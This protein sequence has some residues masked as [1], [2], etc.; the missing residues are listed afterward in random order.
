MALNQLYHSSVKLYSQLT[1]VQVLLS[2]YPNH[3]LFLRNAQRR[4]RKEVVYLI[5]LNSI[6]IDFSPVLRKRK[7]GHSTLSLNRVTLI[8]KTLV[9]FC[10]FSVHVS[11]SIERIVFESSSHIK[12]NLEVRKDNQPGHLCRHNAAFLVCLHHEL[13]CNYYIFHRQLPHSLWRL[14]QAAGWAQVGH[15][16]AL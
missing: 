16:S 10:L 9:C 15:I 7:N 11:L 5:L 2:M 1:G 4:K 12:S 14:D 13:A 6:T 3:S 8:A